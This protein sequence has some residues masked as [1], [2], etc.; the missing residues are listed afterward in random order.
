MAC[1]ND[2]SL[3]L[4]TYSSFPANS[5]VSPIGA[6]RPRGLRPCPRSETSFRVGL[7]TTAVQLTFISIIGRAALEFVGTVPWLTDPTIVIYVSRLRN[8]NHTSLMSKQGSRYLS[9][10]PVMSQSLPSALCPSG[11]ASVAPLQLK[12]RRSSDGIRARGV[13]CR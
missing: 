7:V 10:A 13:H 9:H 6:F 8:M 1:G 3:A 4:T 12:A 2:A 11:K 5:L